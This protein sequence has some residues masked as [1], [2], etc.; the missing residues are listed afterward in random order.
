[1]LKITP[2]LWSA[3]VRNGE[4]LGHQSLAK[5]IQ[6]GMHP[7]IMQGALDWPI[8]MFRFRP[9][10]WTGFTGRKVD[11]AKIALVRE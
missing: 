9:S 2:L 7:P 8:T 4:A 11:C 1:M 3:G 5:A 10:G 6:A